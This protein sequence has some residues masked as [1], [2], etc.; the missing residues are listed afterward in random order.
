MEGRLL[1]ERV[2]RL[3]SEREEARGAVVDKEVQ[4]QSALDRVSAQGNTIL[5]DIDITRKNN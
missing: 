1:H 2:E 4:L 5:Q 3:K